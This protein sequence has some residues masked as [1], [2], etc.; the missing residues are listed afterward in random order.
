MS[1]NFIKKN[2]QKDATDVAI[3]SGIRVAGAFAASFAIHK[4][5]GITKDPTTGK[6]KKTLYN[7]GGPLLLA[8]GVLGDMMIEEPKIRAFCQGLAA[9]GGVHTAA[10][11]SPD[12]LKEEWGI[13]GIAGEE[14][15]E[16]AYLMSGI[17]ALGETTDS[18]AAN[19]MGID[20]DIKELSAGEQV[21]N[22][23][24]GKTYNNDWAYL[25]EN[26]DQ[27]DQITRTVSGV[28]GEDDEQAASNEAA[29]LMGADSEE[30]AAIL[31][32]MF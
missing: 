16:D 1:S 10:V 11:L 26:I 9:Y 32:G 27:A 13:Q 18:S 23:T 20:E 24:D 6:E 21:Y 14:E 17:A 8:A 2:W 3:N 19:M 30:E 29:E 31:M 4:W 25:A 15:E 7:I 12:T 5:L 28:D 22:D